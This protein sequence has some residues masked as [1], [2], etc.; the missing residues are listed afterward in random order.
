M[1]QNVSHQEVDKSNL[2]RI[3]AHIDV[4]GENIRKMDE[5][6]CST[7]RE[8]ECHSMKSIDKHTS[9][10]FAKLNSKEMFGLFRIRKIRLRQTRDFQPKKI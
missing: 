8:R 6:K 5:L 3:M 1:E 7:G 2:A 9:K 4:I 10:K